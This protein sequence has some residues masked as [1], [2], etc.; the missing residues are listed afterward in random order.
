MLYR[1]NAKVIR[2]LS[3]FPNPLRSLACSRN[4]NPTSV[5]TTG[6]PAVFLSTN[7]RSPRTRSGRYVFSAILANSLLPSMSGNLCRHRLLATQGF[8]SFF[9]KCENPLTKLLWSG[10]FDCIHQQYSDAGRM[11]SLLGTSLFMAFSRIWMQSG[12]LLRQQKLLNSLPD[13][14]SAHYGVVAAV[15]QVGIAGSSAVQHGLVTPERS[16]FA[17]PNLLSEAITD[18]AHVVDLAHAA[19]SAFFFDLLLV[20]DAGTYTL[21]NVSGNSDTC[22]DT[23]NLFLQNSY[24]FFYFKTAESTPSL[25]TVDFY[26]YI[27]FVYTRNSIAEDEVNYDDVQVK[28]RNFL[29]ASTPLY[30]NTAVGGAPS[31]I[32]AHRRDLF[33]DLLFFYFN[34]CI[35]FKTAVGGL[36]TNSGNTPAQLPG[37]GFLDANFNFI[38]SVSLFLR[39]P[40]VS[41]SSAAYIPLGYAHSFFNL[42]CINIGASLVFSTPTRADHN[43]LSTRNF[44]AYLGF[45]ASKLPQIFQIKFYMLNRRLRKIMKNSRRYRRIFCYI[46]PSKR[47]NVLGRYIRAFFK[48]TKQRAYT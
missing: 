43:A 21:W 23:Y 12:L 42:F 15:R 35:L 14:L 10:R 13:L 11:P 38:T 3:I 46:R 39:K 29:I 36:F 34:S 31:N 32:S 41:S 5:F 4:N 48:F 30:R 40:L 27:R 37:M 47:A 26:R 19:L 1:F 25:L 18:V 33:W 17:L 45:V 7:K 2:R 16:V 20:S 28:G 22:E 8:N 44:V 6:L 24:A 9:R